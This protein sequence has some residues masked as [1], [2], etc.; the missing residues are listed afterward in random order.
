MTFVVLIAMD[1]K[2]NPP[3]SRLL[4][5]Y[6]NVEKTH[7]SFIGVLRE[8]VAIRSLSQDE[9]HFSDVTQMVTL[10]DFLTLRKNTSNLFFS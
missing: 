9:Q 4:E 2:K 5:L 1:D 7:T 8:A 3:S 10:S 6:E